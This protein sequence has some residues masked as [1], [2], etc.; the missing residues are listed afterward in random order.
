MPRRFLLPLFLAPLA[1]SS[2]IL[3]Q[4]DVQLAESQRY[5]ACLER[6]EEDGYEAL[7]DALTWRNDGGGWP[8]EHC[9]ARSLAQLGEAQAAAHILE[10][11]ASLQRAGMLD[12]ERV[13]LWLEAS[14]ILLEIEAFE[15]A[16][17]NLNAALAL[18]PDHRE[19]LFARA[20]AH[21]GLGDWQA[22]AEDARQLSEIDQAHTPALRL[23]AEA[24]LEL[25]ALEDA[26]RAIMSALQLEPRDIDTLVLRGRIN[27]AQRLAGS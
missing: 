4:T 9:H 12:F 19:A 5:H 7:E 13:A 18:A 26:R 24:S 25:G 16:A 22:V 23:L 2:P 14:E 15:D 6:A 20:R 27:E 21:A 10:D 8:A 11:L 17:A 3:A 1:V